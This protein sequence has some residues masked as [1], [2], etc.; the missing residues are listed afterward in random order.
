M[1]GQWT[2]TPPDRRSLTVAIASSDF[3]SRIKVYGPD[4]VLRGTS[5]ASGFMASSMLV[6]SGDLCGE[7]EYTIVV[8]S[9]IDYHWG[10]YTLTLT[11]G[12]L[13]WDSANPSC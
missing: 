10:D 9:R 12:G 7:G 2:F 1:N 6:L 8:D 5:V 13:I 3:Y 11:P 4:S